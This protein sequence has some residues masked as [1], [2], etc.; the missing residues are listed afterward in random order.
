MTQFDDPYC[1]PGTSVLKNRQDLREPQGALEIER[2]YSLLR[3]RELE[4]KP[5]QGNFGLDHLQEIHRRLYQDVWDWAGRLRT[6]EI[7]KGDS[8]FL[9]TRW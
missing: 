3:R 1:Y 4:V 6:V 5:V 9:Q 7:T 2:E 8:H